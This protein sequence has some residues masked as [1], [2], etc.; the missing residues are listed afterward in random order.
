MVFTGLLSV[1]FLGNKITWSKWLGILIC[2]AGLVIVGFCD[3]LSST[4]APFADINGI[5]TG[6]FRKRSR[7]VDLRR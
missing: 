3:F 1:A 5:I 7:I 6:F 4:N 2:C